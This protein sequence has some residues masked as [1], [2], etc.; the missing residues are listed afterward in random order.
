MR[1]DGRGQLNETY[2]ILTRNKFPGL[3]MLSNP[4]S[5]IHFRHNIVNSEAQNGIIGFELGIIE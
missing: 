1:F 2:G 3:S 5:I 4:S